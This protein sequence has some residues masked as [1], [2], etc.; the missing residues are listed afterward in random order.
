LESARKTTGRVLHLRFRPLRRDDFP[1]LSEWF[2][3]AHVAPWWREAHDI[4]SI[5]QRYGPGIDG[6]DATEVFIV[7]R[8]DEPI[9]MVQRYLIDDNPDWK[10][11][12]EAAG[13]P[14][15]SV[16]IDY[17]IGAETLTG[18]GVGPQMI[19]RFLEQTWRRYPEATAVTVA[20]RHDNR[21]SWRALEKCG[22]KRIWTGELDSEDPSDEGLNYVYILYRRTPVTS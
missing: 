22:F 9:G 12:L 20:V 5:E 11:S 4:A 10:R 1:L 16:G 7:E 2:A 19:G 14:A 21:R 18:Q 13:N 8:D 3:K 6:A 17:L 15:K